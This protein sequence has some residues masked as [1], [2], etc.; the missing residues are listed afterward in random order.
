MRLTKIPVPETVTAAYLVPLRTV[1]TVADARRRTVKAVERRVTG[2]LRML[3]FSGWIKVR[4][5]S[6]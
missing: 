6:R 5:I 3:I 4:W 2:A 1:I